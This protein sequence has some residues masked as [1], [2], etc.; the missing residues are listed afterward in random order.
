VKVA[1]VVPR[2][3]AEVI[4]GCESAVRELS[5]W[6]VR[7]TDVEVEIL[8]TTAA[9]STTWD[10]EY[11]AGTTQEAGVAVHRFPV[12]SGRARDCDAR[13]APL[14]ARARSLTP[15]EQQAW[16]ELQ[17]PVSPALVDAVAATDADL[18]SI[19]PYLFWPDVAA[20]AAARVPVVFHPY[21]HD[22]APLRLS[23]YAPLFEASAGLVFQVDA[24]RRLCERRFAIAAR[25]ALTLGLGVEAGTGSAADA[26]AAVGLGDR[27]YLLCLGRVD[28]GKGARLLF[29]WFTAYKE[30]RPGPLALVYAG[31]VVHELPSHSDIVVVGIV[32][33]PVKWGLLRGTVALVSPSANE[34]F[35]LVLLEAWVAGVPAMVNGRC[36]VTREH[37][38]RSGGG[39]WFDGYA[40]FEAMLDRLGDAD[41]RAALAERGA[42]YVDRSY[43]W[44][45]LVSRY[46][47]FLETCASVGSD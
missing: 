46:E 13:S 25:R 29:D 44:P 15:T 32:D 4:G 3:G 7:C 36:A 20:H 22:E 1:A 35:S 26:S 12:T 10:E 45:T 17:G 11:P 2:Y 37:C 34:S 39:L 38:E 23:V 6:L 5:E 42:A 40:Q 9:D 18:L 14:M 31:Q 19:H 8:T 28:D 41:L 30:R 24:E 43:R 33:E 21:A 47:A 27:P 16:L